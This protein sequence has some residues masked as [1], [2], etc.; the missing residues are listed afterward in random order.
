MDIAITEDQFGRGH[1]IHK[2]RAPCT[3]ASL[4]INLI[5]R[6]GLVAAK[7]DGEDS[8]GR[9]KLELLTPEELVNRACDT[10]DLVLK[11]CEARGW[12]LPIPAPQPD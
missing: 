1:A 10:A 11:E 9:A 2:L 3:E 7:P 5:E 12:M 6:W 8:A 4:A